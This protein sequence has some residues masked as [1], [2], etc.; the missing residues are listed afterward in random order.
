MFGLSGVEEVTH[1]FKTYSK[2]VQNVF[3]FRLQTVF[4]LCHEK[5]GSKDFTQGQRQ[6]KAT[7]LLGTHLVVC[8]STL[9]LPEVDSGYD[10]LREKPADTQRFL[11]LP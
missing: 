9:R 7:K 10:R 11:K 2:R 4:V 3:A 6:H 1:V 8:K 5:L